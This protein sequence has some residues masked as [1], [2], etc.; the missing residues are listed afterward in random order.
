MM[1][2]YLIPRQPAIFRVGETAELKSRL[3]LTA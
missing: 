2:K 1:A 3:G